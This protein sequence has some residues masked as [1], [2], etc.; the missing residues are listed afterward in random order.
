VVAKTKQERD[1][2]FPATSEHESSAVF[3]VRVQFFIP[4]LKG[5]ETAISQNFHYSSPAQEAGAQD[6]PSGRKS[7]GN[8]RRKRSGEAALRK[9]MKRTDFC[10]LS[11]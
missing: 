9:T 3:T 7:A 8:R 5:A 1:K 4:G 6:V 2:R 11:L 10:I